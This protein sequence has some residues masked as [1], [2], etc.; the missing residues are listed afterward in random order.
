MW[1]SSNV[2]SCWVD[3]YYLFNLWIFLILNVYVSTF[4]M[5][6]NSIIIKGYHDF[7]NMNDIIVVVGDDDN[8][9]DFYGDVYGILLFFVVKV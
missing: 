4:D 6:Y 8:G 1:V 9:D 7:Y 2:V 5:H 3:I